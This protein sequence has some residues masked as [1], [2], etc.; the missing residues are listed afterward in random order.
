MTRMRRI[1]PP[2]QSIRDVTFARL[3]CVIWMRLIQ[4]T[5]EG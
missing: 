3:P 1:R 5:E 2:L 4:M